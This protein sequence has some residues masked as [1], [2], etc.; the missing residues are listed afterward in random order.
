MCLVHLDLTGKLELQAPLDQLETRGLEVPQESRVF[1]DQR[2]NWGRKE[3]M[4]QMVILVQLENQDYQS[5]SI[6]GRYAVLNKGYCCLVQG[7]NGLA[8]PVGLPGT[9]GGTVSVLSRYCLVAFDYDYCGVYRFYREHLVHREMQ[10]LLVH[11]E[12]G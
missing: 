4:G 11:K 3:Q 9:E 12:Q 6:H 2:E 5:V 10:A 7:R 8:G 1:L